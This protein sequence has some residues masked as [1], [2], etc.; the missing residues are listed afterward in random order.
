MTII[1]RV[2]AKKAISYFNKVIKK[3]PKKFDL[4]AEDMA[5][6]CRK[7]ARFRLTTRRQ[8]GSKHGNLLW[9][10]LQFRKRAQ[11]T[12][13]CWQNPAIAHYGWVIERGVKGIKFVPTPG[14][15]QWGEGVAKKGGRL[16]KKGGYHFMRDAARSTM[17]RSRRISERR[18]KELIKG[19]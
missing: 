7:G 19:G 2:D 16:P 5:K 15:G 17:R 10:S 1:I 4:A 18:V 14:V 3:A 6:D 9:R 11:G 12:W 13:E 8:R